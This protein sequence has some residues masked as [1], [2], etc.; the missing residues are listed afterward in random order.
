MI[1]SVLAFK[2]GVGK[3]SAAVGVSHVGAAETGEPVLLIDGDPQGSAFGW[4]ERAQESGHPLACAT[5]AL[6]SAN[7][8]ARLAALGTERYSLV[9]IDTPPGAGTIAAGALEVADVALL[10]TKPTTTDLDRLWPTWEATQKAG[11]PALVVLS[12]ARLGSRS[13]TAARQAL[14]DGGAHVARTVI[15]QR[16]GIAQAFGQVPSGTLATLAIDLLAEIF[17]T[18]ERTQ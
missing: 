3:T 15:P 13:I 8:R 17:E 5:I 10:P 4:S 12:M 16:E 9:V 7:M 1:V 2:G 14:T 6:P 18:V 11:V